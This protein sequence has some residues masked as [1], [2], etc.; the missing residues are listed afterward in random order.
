MRSRALTV[1]Q[2][3][4][5]SYAAIAVLRVCVSKD[6]F[7]AHSWQ[8]R[9]RECNGCILAH[10]GRPRTVA[11]GSGKLKPIQLPMRAFALSSPGPSTD[12]CQTSSRQSP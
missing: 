6:S 4:R 5:A 11:G 3:V 1:A 12:P 10:R 8:V 2:G 9:A 7:L